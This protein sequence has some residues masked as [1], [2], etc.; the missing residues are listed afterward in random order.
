MY[1]YKI[2]ELLLELNQAFKDGSLAKCFADKLKLQQP[3]AKE[4]EE[5]ARPILPILDATIF[6][7]Y[8][9]VKAYE[10]FIKSSPNCSLFPPK[11]A[12]LVIVGFLMSIAFN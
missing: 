12:F 8:F 4:T 11:E 3:D 5:C 1:F 2:A 7:D 6:I 9:F 10:K